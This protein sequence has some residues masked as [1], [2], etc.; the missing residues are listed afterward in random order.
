M[1]FDCSFC[2]LASIASLVCRTRLT[3]CYNGF[4]SI[5]KQIIEKRLTIVVR[6]VVS[7]RCVSSSH[8]QL[9]KSLSLRVVSFASTCKAR[10]SLLLK[11]P[12][13]A[14]KSPSLDSLT[15]YFP[16]TFPIPSPTTHPDLISP[17]DLHRE[18]DLLR[19]PSSFR[20]W[21][22]AITNT[23][24]SLNALQKAERGG[25]DLPDEV[26]V[27]LG[28]LATTLGRQSLQR[29]TY[30]Y[31]AALVQFPGSFKLWKSY[32]QMRMS[33]VLGRLIPKKKSGGKKKFPEMKDALEEE[34]GELEEWEGGL[35]GVV[36]WEEWKSLIAT[37]ERA[38]MW[39]PK[40]RVFFII[41]RQI[42][43][44]CGGVTVTSIM[45]HVSL[46]IQPP[47]LPSSHLPHPRQT[48]IRPSPSNPCAL[49]PFTDMDALPPMVR[50]PGRLDYC[51]GLQK[52]SSCRS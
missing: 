44:Y 39:L 1:I 19:N 51:S 2:F 50:S 17:K 43:T 27:L 46:H 47:P 36:G 26:A 24:E 9:F 4:K 7:A 48:H 18:E 52:I 23:R 49:P 34:R 16:L 3:L 20:A 38:L 25:S 29:L 11:M 10:G 5:L 31:E 28:P 42:L 14:S 33:Y 40:V 35:D 30:L 15:S 21:W 37:Y 8:I 45:A 41:P 22:T 6:G 12:S 32:L 13:V